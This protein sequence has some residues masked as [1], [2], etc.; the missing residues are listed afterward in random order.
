MPKIITIDYVKLITRK[1][2]PVLFVNYS[3]EMQS[4]GGTQTETANIKV[5]TNR[6]AEERERAEGV[7]F[8]RTGVKVEK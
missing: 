6:M 2:N 7:G 4:G 8:E 5:E 3:V 1:Y